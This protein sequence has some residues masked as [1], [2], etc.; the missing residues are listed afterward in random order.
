MNEPTVPTSD[1][2]LEQTVAA[3]A[4]AAE[5]AATA[6]PAARA[7]WLAS[8]AEALTTAADALVQVAQEETHLPEPRLRGELVRTTFQLG[9]FADVLREGSYLGVRIDHADP[10]WGMGPRPDLRRMLRPL[11]PVA[12]W[13]AGNFPF[14]FSVAGG[15]T[16]S[17]LAA[18]CPVV[19]K[20]HPGHLRLSRLTSQV[21]TDAL[22][23]AGA[24]DGLFGLVVGTE[25]G[26]RLVSDPRIKAGAFT[27]SL[28]GGRALFDL[29]A[30]RPDPIPFF[31]E[32]GSVN[33]V[34]VTPGAAE[35]RAR[36][37]ADGF[38]GSATLGVGQF[39]T[40]PGL[41]FVPSGSGLTERLAE[42]ATGLPG[43]PMLNE[44]THE[45]FATA[46]GELA[47]RPEVAVLAG[48]PDVA[49]EPA[50]T[51]FA[52]TYDQHARAREQLE[53]ECFGPAALIV[54][55]DD[56]GQ[57]VEAAAAIDG[58]LTATV[59][60]TE[61]ETGLVGSLLDVLADRAG[62]VLW[63]GWPTG[64]SVTH[65]M[66]HGG[67]YPATTA[68]STTSVG[69]AAVERFLRPVSFQSV[70]DGLLPPP[71]REANPWDVP[72]RVDGILEHS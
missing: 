13:S 67:P 51:L 45:G 14:A 31:G 68:A 9:L 25:N 24:P 32:L 65:A 52:T 47:A 6:T 3:A 70:P 46:V 59:Q 64:V 44:R 61:T 71:L 20:A 2:E 48:S 19:V 17:A 33:P 49:A 10:E 29:A 54:S 69:T 35:H 42:A 8:V 12:V 37:I 11:G 16:A 28:A 39:C 41:V 36:E 62:R 34:F 22:R 26:R 60:G 21:V 7:G 55:Y 40:K 57:L 1:A 23:A 53:V 72:R 58:Q 18:G 63:N 50:L 27:G 66:E 15:D 4:A 30:A 38:V 43:A 56:P 5:Q